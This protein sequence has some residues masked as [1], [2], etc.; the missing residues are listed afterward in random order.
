M[1][2]S[3]LV[4]RVILKG[5]L[6]DGRFEPEEILDMA[7]D[8]LLSE[9][10]P[11]ITSLRKE[12]YVVPEI[13]PIEAR[14][15]MPTRALGEVL[16]EL[17]L[18]RNGQR[19][20]LYQI[21][22][23][24]IYTL[25]PGT[26]EGFYMQGLDAVLHPAPPAGS[27]DEIYRSY[28]FRPSQLVLESQCARVASFD[29]LTGIITA[30]TPNTWTNGKYDIITQKPGHK[31]LS[32]DLESTSV[33]GGSITFPALPAGLQIG[34]Y[35]AEANTTPWAQVP[36]LVYNLLVQLTVVDC[37]EE[38]GSTAEKQSASEKLNRLKGAV[39]S[40]LSQ[41]VQGAPLRFKTRLL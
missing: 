10:V 16:R 9:V 6:P 26:P 1:I 14:M 4:E 37:L 27:T 23:E 17:V 20:P 2:N 40:T 32:F 34:D 3:K 11:L 25:D 31:C 19:F 36:D 22:P 7:Y 24:D 28:F 41:R 21:S 13:V 8:C 38:M 30:T 18:L 15:E 29:P 35:V 33:G 12:F 5:A 39:I